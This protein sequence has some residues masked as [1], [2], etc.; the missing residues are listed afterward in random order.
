MLNQ[1]PTPRNISVLPAPPPPTTAPPAAPSPTTLA[2]LQQLHADLLA[3]VT[4]LQPL[5]PA[6]S[7][8][9]IMAIESTLGTVNS[10]PFNRL[11]SYMVIE[12]YGSGNAA[13]AATIQVLDSSRGG[14]PTLAADPQAARVLTGNYTKYVIGGLQDEIVVRVIPTLGVWAVR[15]SWT[16]ASP[17]SGQGVFAASFVNESANLATLATAV[18]A[19]VIALPLPAAALANRRAIVVYNNGSVP[20]YIGDALVTTAT[21]I[22]LA[23]GQSIALNVG[24]GALVY[25]ISGSATQNVRCLEI[26]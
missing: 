11:G 21:G 5:Q 16:D 6:D 1:P 8:Q 23:V 4:A 14:T 24:P 20:I 10:Q 12:A 25:A 3:V 13:P 22:P 26:S 7:P 17:G 15:V 2:V 18:T 19:G 9:G